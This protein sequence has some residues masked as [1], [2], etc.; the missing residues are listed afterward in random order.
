MLEPTHNAAEEAQALNRVHRIGQTHAVRCVIFYVKNSI[1][2]RVLALRQLQGQ[3]TEILAN[4]AE[5]MDENDDMIMTAGQGVGASSSSSKRGPDDDGD[6]EYSPEER[7]SRRK[8]SKGRKEQKN[9]RYIYIY[10]N[11]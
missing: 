3:L 9:K 7:S 6:E 11:I 4:S 2:E 10:T 1:E 8:A 5:N